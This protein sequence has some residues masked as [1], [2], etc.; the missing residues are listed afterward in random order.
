MKP[1]T[2]KELSAQIGFS[3]WWICQARKAGMPFQCGRTTLK[4]ADEWRRSHPSFVAADWVSKPS[5]TGRGRPRKDAGK[6]GEQPS[7][8]VKR[9]ALPDLGAH[10]H[11]QASSQPLPLYNE[12][13]NLSS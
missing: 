13:N 11:A 8:S 5:S 6:S 2:A 3:E 4:E 1:L 10:L 12:N 7:S 9:S